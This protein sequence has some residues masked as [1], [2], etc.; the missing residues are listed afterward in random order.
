[1]NRS[2]NEAVAEV[3]ISNLDQTS[4]ES[5]PLAQKTTEMLNFVSSNGPHPLVC[6]SLVDSF[7]DAKFG[8]D[9]HFTIHQSKYFV[10]KAIDA[11]FKSAKELPNSL[12]FI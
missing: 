4:T 12:A 1:M 5:R 8:T 3:E 9:W 7:L 6:M 2:L 11:H 10:S